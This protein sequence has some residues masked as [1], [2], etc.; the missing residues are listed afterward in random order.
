[1]IYYKGTEEPIYDTSVLNIE[2]CCQD[3][4]DFR[5]TPMGYEHL[6]SEKR[7][8]RMEQTKNQRRWFFFRTLVFQLPKQTQFW[9]LR[10]LLLFQV[11]KC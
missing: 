3:N 5:L 11:T 8:R 1:M 4:A 10:V 9:N 6:A 7:L 2:R